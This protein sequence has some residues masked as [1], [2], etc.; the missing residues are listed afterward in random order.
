MGSQ[1]VTAK[2][3]DQAYQTAFFQH[4]QQTCLAVLL[5]LVATNR[6]EPPNHGVVVIISNSVRH[7]SSELGCRSD[8][9][10]P[11]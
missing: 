9:I 1:L 5:G 4:C 11:L 2:A 10:S 6:C 3:L 8:T 7:V